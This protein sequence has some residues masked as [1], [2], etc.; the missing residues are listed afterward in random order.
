MVIF[1]FGQILIL[2][3][4]TANQY[5]YSVYLYF[6]NTVSLNLNYHLYLEIY[7]FK[8]II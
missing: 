7:F 2:T 1:I 6:S 5:V 3:H 8:N 4:L